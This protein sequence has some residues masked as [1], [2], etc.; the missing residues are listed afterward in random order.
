MRKHNLSW[1][2]KWKPLIVFSVV[3]ILMYLMIGYDHERVHQKVYSNYGI[4]SKIKMFPNPETIPE[5]KCPTS[6]CFLAQEINEAV[7]YNTLPFFWL[8]STG[9]FVIIYC[10]VN[11]AGVSK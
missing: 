9:F 2:D 5:Y 4:P 7:G 6:D 11:R 8:I 1:F 10:L 3:V